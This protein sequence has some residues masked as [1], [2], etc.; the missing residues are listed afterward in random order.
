MILEL[1]CRAVIDGAALGAFATATQRH[2][3]KELE[4]RSQR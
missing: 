2:R 3:G 1:W 4:F